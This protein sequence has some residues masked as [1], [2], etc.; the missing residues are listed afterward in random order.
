MSDSF[1]YYYYPVSLRLNPQ[2]GGNPP[3]PTPD[4]DRDQVIGLIGVRVDFPSRRAKL[5]RQE[6]H[7]SWLGLGVISFAISR[8]I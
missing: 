7:A 2:S 6:G 3:P 8:C 4:P 5:D 1:S